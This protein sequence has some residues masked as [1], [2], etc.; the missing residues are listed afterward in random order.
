MEIDKFGSGH[1]INQG[2]YKAFLPVKINTSWN[3]RDPEINILLEQASREL[4]G[5]N[6]FS[7]LIPNIDVYI[8]MHIRTEANKSSRIEGTKTSIE[9]ELMDIEDIAPEKRA[10]YEEVRNYIE[11]MNYG[12]NRIQNDNFPLTTRLIRELHSTLMQGVRGERKTPGEFRISQN[13]IGGTS[14]SNAVFVPPSVA[15]MQELLSDFEKF[16]HNDEAQIP[17]LIKAAIIHYQFET[18]HPFLDGNGRIGR[19][20]IP[21]Y[22]L[23]KKILDKPCF[24]ISDFFEKNRTQYYDV[25][26]NVRV[27][28]DLAN[29]IKFFLKAVIYTAKSA[30]YKF[31]KVVELVKNYEEQ[32]LPFSG[33]AE[34][35][36]AILKAFFNEPILT[37]RQLQDKT[38]LRQTTI[39]RILKTMLEKDM[40]FELTG[41]SRNRIYALGEYII[42]FARKNDES[43]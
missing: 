42:I 7:D 8:Q 43:L 12:I 32:M 3:W 6:S 33:K 40:L 27:K 36:R 10:D 16:I 22:L 24:Y 28:N 25:L 5:L 1:F 34:N 30:K 14:P 13:W 17:H 23:E 2:G 37:G 26:Q 19:L 31:K 18:I 4:G 35:K 15:D 9:E 41:Y 21:L 38:S 29:W 20:I 39:D 11:A